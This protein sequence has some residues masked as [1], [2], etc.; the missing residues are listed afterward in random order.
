MKRNVIFVIVVLLMLDVLCSCFLAL[1]ASFRGRGL[2]G[3]VLNLPAGYTGYVMKE[4]KRPFT[5]E[6][7]RTKF[8][9]NF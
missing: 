8:V 6:E 7:V 5:D 2:Q 9:D 4:E 1:T 3:C